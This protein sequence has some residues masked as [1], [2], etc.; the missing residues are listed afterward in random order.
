MRYKRKYRRE[1]IKG[2]KADYKPSRKYN[3]RQ[4]RMGVKVER[5]HTY[6]RRIAREIAKDH[7]EEHPRYYTYLA[8]ME[9]RLKKKRRYKRW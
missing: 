9:R 2:G 7:L 1:Y 6:N 8:R 5:E 4:L 3:R